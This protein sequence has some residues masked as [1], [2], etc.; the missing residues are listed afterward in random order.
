MS[1][2]LRETSCFVL[3]NLYFYIQRF[4]VIKLTN[5][6]KYLQNAD[7]ISQKFIQLTLTFCPIPQPSLTVSTVM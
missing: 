7:H 3:A 2:E 6:F 1:D 5:N 4:N